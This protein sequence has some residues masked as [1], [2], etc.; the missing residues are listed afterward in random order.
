MSQAKDGGG[1]SADNKGG[2]GRHADQAGEKKGRSAA[3]WTTLIAS[4]AVVLA[5]A[6]LVVFDYFTRGTQPPVIEVTPIM[7]EVR[8][9]GDSFYLPVE[10]ANR[11]AVTAEAVAIELTLKGS[12]GSEETAGFM[13]DFLAGGETHHQT[14]VFGTDPRQ[15][16]L[17][18]VASFSTP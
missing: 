7:E 2:K 12:D 1:G 18:H 9:E 3:E 6:G 4:V 11:G 13:V 5:L 17:E 16:E 14:V 15:G 10:I 8:I